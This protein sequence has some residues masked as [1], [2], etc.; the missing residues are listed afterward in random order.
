ML[1]DVHK[2]LMSMIKG[3]IVDND[4]K[5]QL[6]DKFITLRELVKNLDYKTV[7]NSYDDVLNDCVAINDIAGLI[8]LNN[9]MARVFFD[10]ADYGNAYNYA[11]EVLKLLEEVESVNR[12]LD[13][14]N[15]FAKLLIRQEA[16]QEAVELLKKGLKTAHKYNKS[17]QITKL[18]NSIGEAYYRLKQYDHA[19]GYLINA[20]EIAKE[21]KY[22]QITEIKVN[23]ALLYTTKGVYNV[24]KI[25]VLEAE[26]EATKNSN[27]F[28]LI[29][30]YLIH[31]NIFYEKK[32]YVLAINYANKSELLAEKYEFNFELYCA[33]DWL[34]KAYAKQGDFQAAYI[35]LKKYSDLLKQ[36]NAINRESNLSSM[37]IKHEIVQYEKEITRIKT[38]Y[39]KVTQQRQ[40][41]QYIIDILGKQNEELLSIAINDY[42]TG[43]YNRKYFMLKFDEEFSI[44]DESG[45][46]LSCLVFD[47]D[48]FKG[49]NDTYGHI[50]GDNVMKHIVNVCSVY[51]DENDIVGRFGGD[52]FVIILMGKNIKA[53]CV[54]GNKILETLQK[55]PIVVEEV[56]IIATISLGVTDNKIGHPNKAEDMIRI[57]DKALYEAKDNGRNQ[58]CIAHE[59]LQDMNYTN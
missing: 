25:Y 35:S 39:E 59:A 19:E 31:A 1:L 5:N 42:L 20:L 30:C 46:D 38:N 14:L 54:I 26:L 21:H 45:K 10:K 28:L 8:E 44:A 32:K 56:E 48:K 11:V 4:I 52:E 49:I 36:M 41:L 40:E 18:F 3:K 58:L 15:C 47:I 50:A 55:S 51:T 34:H 23:L 29:W 37:R 6:H 17:K 24:A 22:S 13:N 43:A 2:H 53:A 7:I 16:F 9:I 33:Y 57:A 12:A 27:V